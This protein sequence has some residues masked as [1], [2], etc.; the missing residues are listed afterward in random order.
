M[1]KVLSDVVYGFRILLKNPAFAAIAVITLGLGIGGNT[2]IFSVVNSVL[3]R[4][5]PYANSDQLVI[6]NETKLPQFPSFSVSPGN[7]LDWRKQA[8]AFENIAVT[9]SGPSILTGGGDPAK[10]SGR[11]ATANL[12]QTLR[13]KPALG[14]DFTPEEDQEGHDDVVIISYG[15]WQR[16]FGGKPEILGQSVTLNNRSYTVI[17]VMPAG[18]RF[19]GDI[20]LWKPMAFT[21]DEMKIHG[22]HYLFCVAR[23]KDGESVERATAELATIAKGLEEQYPNANRGWGIKLTPVLDFA[24]GSIRPILLV[25]LGA[26]G[27]V[28][29]IACANVANLLLARASTREKEFGIRAALGAGRMRLLS[30]MLTESVVLALVGGLLGVAIAAVGVR[31]L[32]R[33]A[34]EDLPRVKQ[35]A[36]DM[37]ALGFTFLLTLLTGVIFGLAPALQFS[38]PNLNDSL[39]EGGRGSTSGGRQIIR[40]SLVVVE[41][42]MALVLLIGAGLLIKSFSRLAAVNPGFRIDHG[43]A[44]EVNLPGAKYAKD[45]QQAAF[46]ESLWRRAATLPGVESVGATNVM[47]LSGNDYILGFNIAGRPPA[48][49][50]EGIST[51]YY[52]V[53]PDYFRAMG[54]P[55][56][57]GRYF[58][59]ADSR[60]SAHVAIINQAMARRVFP[61]QDPIGQRIN[62]TNGDDT[63]RE[64][65]GVVADV[66]HYAL[67]APAPLQT[68]EPFLQKPEGGMT[69][70]LRTTV[71]PASL[72]QAVR[73][74][75]LELDKDQPISESN[76][77]ERLFSDSVSRQRFGM[78]LLAVFAGIA[79]MLAAVGIYGVLSYSVA[80]RMHEIGIRMALG[81]RMTDVLRI[82][83]GRAAGLTLIGIALGLGGAFLITRVMTSMLFG[84]TPTDPSTFIAIP[85]LLS[86]VALAA[87]YLPSRRAARIDPSVALSR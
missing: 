79:L 14:R 28:L 84:V 55:L 32:P 18:F 86:L 81:A 29:L 54:I 58:S 36:I 23:I 74:T 41:V 46:F 87:S 45:Q 33:F 57:K 4:P 80:Q 44:V 26:V 65:V 19:G 76:T 83:V 47:P 25:L 68:Y 63:F 35:I 75:V 9:A 69:L 48:A 22:G 30:Q 62:V 52:A 43:L 85:I 82:V 2:A 12:F 49:P 7:F 66:K 38:K 1:E 50:G 51:N 39:K 78:L 37:R 15:L 56:I 53:S 16:R 67:D 60:D 70:V 17:G 42:A 72:T 40:S 3:L 61:D 20:D 8:T 11:R 31:L 24:V 64:I 10:V 13:V 59:D 5:L 77:L 34:P 27:F 21:A 71:D 6:I 73:E